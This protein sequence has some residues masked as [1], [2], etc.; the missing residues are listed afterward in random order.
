MSVY[1]VGTNKSSTNVFP[2]I[3]PSLD[4][5]FANTKTLDPRITFTRASGG[6]YV[7]ADGLIK[8]AGVNEARF[9]HDPETGE[10]LGL[11]IEE[12]RAN[13]L[14]RSEEFDDAIWGKARVSLNI[15]NILS[16][17][18]K[19]N[20]YK[21][22]EDTSNNTH[23]IL[24]SFSFASSTRYTM[25]IFAKAAE[26]GS[27]QIRLQGTPFGGTAQFANFDIINGKVNS[28]GGGGSA[29]IFQ[30]GNGWYRCSITTSQTTSSASVNVLYYLT[31]NDSINYQGDG[32]S[33]LFL[34]GAQLE[35]QAFLS[36]YI[37]TQGSTRTRA[38][39]SAV[40]TGKN[41]SSWYRQ[42]EGTVFAEYARFAP[43]LLGTSRRLFEIT[44]GTVNN[45][46]ST[47]VGTGTNIANAF[48]TKDG[49]G[50]LSPSFTQINMD[51]FGGKSAFAFKNN[52]ISY[53]Y[54]TQ[55]LL[56]SFV[57]SI[58]EVMI[59]AN[60][61]SAISPSTFTQ[62]NGCISRL[63]YYPKRLSNEQLQALTR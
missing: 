33:G 41:F 17:D 15:S 61:G 7:G 8:Y 42:D 37:P 49:A 39:D 6:S 59:Q 9:D 27:I 44:D 62:A 36:S 56:R 55:P 3:R 4:L 11:L 51:S 23:Q 40:I 20:P 45:R 13:S 24:Q 1:R 22:I 29:N 38:R 19:S 31:V 52:N 47:V 60:I 26:R 58:P 10:S 57:G 50:Q 32:A 43:N 25:S 21:F 5:D 35:A 48:I 34:W 30:L 63:T 54:K 12:P 14:L 18:G 53:S 2:S 28:V 16:P 46:I